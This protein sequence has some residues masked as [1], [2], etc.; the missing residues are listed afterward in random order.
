MLSLLLASLAYAQKPTYGLCD[1]NN[2][3]Q[4][5]NVNKSFPI[6][7]AL[8]SGAAVVISGDFYIID[9]CRFGLRNFVFYNA[10]GTKLYGGFPN[11]PDGITLSDDLVSPS[12]SPSTQTFEFKKVAG[13]EA[14]FNGFSQVRFFAESL[15][16]VVATVDLPAPSA[17]TG[18]S[19]ST[20][21]G[22]SSAATTTS[23]NGAISQDA[24]TSTVVGFLL[25]FLF[26]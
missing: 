2:F 15:Q 14:N 13:A 19:G 3:G 12:S 25:G 9:G 11:S 8:A 24:I 18:G 4:A 21:T 23:K 26:I 5:A 16:Q 22:S 6:K 1:P 7:P 17:S 20:G 10:Q